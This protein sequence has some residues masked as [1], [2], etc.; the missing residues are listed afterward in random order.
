MMAAEL[1]K[2]IE[3]TGV[4]IVQAESPACE[5]FTVQCR[6]NAP[7]QLSPGDEKRAG[8]F[9]PDFHFTKKSPA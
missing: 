9:R 4:E 8:R 5:S 7:D 2:G 1:E 3:G 6:L